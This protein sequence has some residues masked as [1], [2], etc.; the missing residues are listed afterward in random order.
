MDQVDPDQDS[1]P[2]PD[3]N[4]GWQATVSLTTGMCYQKAHLQEFVRSS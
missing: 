3:R 2:D 4:T 1:D